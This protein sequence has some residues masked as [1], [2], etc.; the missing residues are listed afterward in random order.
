MGSI[1][2]A[3]SAAIVLTIL[4]EAL[5]GFDNYRMLIYSLALVLMMLFRPSGLLG[6]AEFSLA[7]VYDRLFV[8]TPETL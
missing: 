7:R 1:T 2:G 3:V 4:P 8:K 5:R 6:T